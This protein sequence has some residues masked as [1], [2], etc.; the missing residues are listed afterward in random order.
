M[1]NGKQPRKKKPTLDTHSLLKALL[2]AAVR[3]PFPASLVHDALLLRR[4]R[5]LLLVLDGSLEEALQSIM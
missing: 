4:A 3:A 2:V 5:V 1:E